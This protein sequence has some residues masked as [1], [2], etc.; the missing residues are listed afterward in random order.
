MLG[1]YD[2]ILCPCCGHKINN[3]IDSV[4]FIDG[5]IPDYMQ[6]P[7]IQIRCIKC[8]YHAN[9]DIGRVICLEIIKN[10]NNFNHSQRAIEYKKQLGKE[11]TKDIKMVEVKNKVDLSEIKHLLH[12]IR[13]EFVKNGIKETICT[14]YL[15]NFSIARGFSAPVS[16]ENYNQELGEKY[17]KENC[18]K[19]LESKL[20]ELMGFSLFKKINPDLFL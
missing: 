6:V 12:Q 4:E 8:N 5:G 16:A 11:K 18:V 17:A 1:Y 19:E 13:Y 10:W 20:W 15:G 2:A 7:L 3:D 9:F 14:A